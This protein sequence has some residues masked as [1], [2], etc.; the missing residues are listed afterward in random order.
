MDKQSIIDLFRRIGPQPLRDLATTTA[1]KV[2]LVVAHCIFS[3]GGACDFVCL[4]AATGD[5]LSS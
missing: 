1:G 5:L 3:S 2:G 4:A